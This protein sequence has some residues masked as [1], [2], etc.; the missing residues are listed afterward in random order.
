MNFS[1]VILASCLVLVACQGN[2]PRTKDAIVGPHVVTPGLT[3]SGAGLTLPPAG[4][5]AVRSADTPFLAT[6]TPNPEGAAAEIV[7]AGANLHDRG[8]PVIG[9]SFGLV[10]EN[11]A[12]DGQLALFEN[13]KPLLTQLSAKSNDYQELGTA[14]QAHL[15]RPWG[16]T[17][18]NLPAVAP[19]PALAGL[20]IADG[21]VGRI[22]FV[23]SDGTSIQTVVGG[24]NEIPDYTDKPARAVQLS[25]PADLATGAD[26]DGKPL[27]VIAERGKHRILGWSPEAGTVSVL[28]GTGWPA[29]TRNHL[30]TDSA[31]LSTEVGDLVA[32]VAGSGNPQGA[33]FTDPTGVAI[34]PFD[35]DRIMIYVADTGNHR[36]RRIRR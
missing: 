1:P 33:A 21:L 10:L 31:T 24:G 6:A 25:D 16:I 13:S 23:P 9:C 32:G 19:G 30:A 5:T 34:A 11:F 15:S 36:I 2:L 17:P 27:V 26:W 29:F 4:S 8:L 22:R 20:L 12:G 28:A 18:F 7:M 35:A 3:E 14:K